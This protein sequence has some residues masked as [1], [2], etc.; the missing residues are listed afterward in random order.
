[1]TQLPDLAAGCS[2]ADMA[3]IEQ[4]EAAGRCEVVW[5]GRDY[6]GRTLPSGTYIVRLQTRSSTVTR[7]VML[8]Q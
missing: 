3:A 8:V 4:V 2:M 5:D 7:K 6:R 1:M